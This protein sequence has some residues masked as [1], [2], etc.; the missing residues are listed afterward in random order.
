MNFIPDNPD[1]AKGQALGIACPDCWLP[2][3]SLNHDLP[4][5]CNCPDRKEKFADL[6]REDILST[7]GF[8]PNTA[9]RGIPGGVR[10][11]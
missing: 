8:D 11:D 10:V 7:L 9:T 6:K 5:K 1:Q 2:V 3:G 4:G